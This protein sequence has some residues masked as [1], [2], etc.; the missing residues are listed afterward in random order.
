MVSSIFNVCSFGITTVKHLYIGSR[1]L[2]G[3]TIVF[4]ID[5][6]TKT[7]TTESVIRVEGWDADASTAFMGGQTI[8]W[9]EVPNTG[10]NISFEEVY[11]EG[12]QGKTYIKNLSFQLP[13]VNFTTNAGLKEFIFTA[14]GEFAIS[15]AVCWIIDN[16]SQKWI[17]GYDLPLILLDGME[18]VVADEN[19]YKLSFK[20]ISYSRT[21]N[22]EIIEAY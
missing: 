6:I 20:S 21:R 14:D 10:D 1:Q 8:E 19:Y 5:Y 7:G 17:I 15:N 2:N 4:P 13:L 16:N 11:E 9:R 3:S 12:K 22:Y 18:L